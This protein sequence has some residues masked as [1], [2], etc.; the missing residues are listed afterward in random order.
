MANEQDVERIAL[1][2]PETTKDPDGF[3][4]SVR[5]KGIAWSYMERVASDRPR[6]R[7]S[8]VLAVRVVDEDEKEIMI[9]VNPDA[10]FTTDHYNGYPAVLVNLPAIDIDELEDL[11]TTADDRL[12][13]P[14]APPPDRGIR[15]PQRMNPS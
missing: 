13:N 7:R 15:C 1:S 8:D 3:S 10:F 14:R 9:A 11:L 4:F 2:L 5:K 6:V 12:A